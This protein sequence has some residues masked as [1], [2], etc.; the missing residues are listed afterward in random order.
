MCIHSAF[1]L[2]QKPAL[3]DTRQ[4]GFGFLLIYAII[5][6]IINLNT[7]IK[8]RNYMNAQIPNIR[9][10]RLYHVTVNW[11]TKQ[12]KRFMRE[13]L[14]CAVNKHD[15][16]CI[17]KNHIPKQFITTSQPNDI[18][19]IQIRVRDLGL[20]QKNRTYFVSEIIETKRNKIDEPSV[21]EHTA[22]Y[23]AYLFGYELGK[24][25]QTETLSDVQSQR[26]SVMS[27]IKE[28]TQLYWTW[29]AD[30]LYQKDMDRNIFFQEKL[31]DLTKTHNVNN[32]AQK[33]IQT[34][35]PMNTASF[36]A[37]I[38]QAK[39][40][41]EI[42]I[43]NANEMAAAI[44]NN[45]KETANVLIH[46]AKMTTQSV[47]SEP[48][49]KEPLVIS[50]NE[51]ETESKSVSETNDETSSKPKN[52][53]AESERSESVPKET[54]SEKQIPDD[55]ET[56]KSETSIKTEVKPDTHNNEK[57]S[58][59]SID[60]N[61]C[62][63]IITNNLVQNIKWL[64]A[65]PETE[66]PDKLTYKELGD[67]LLA[68]TDDEMKTL[69]QDKP[70]NFDIQITPFEYYIKYIKGDA[71]ALDDAK[72]NTILAILASINQTETKTLFQTYMFDNIQKKLESEM[73]TKFE[74][75]DVM[76]DED[77]FGDDD[78]P[79]DFDEEPSYDDEPSYEDEPNYDDETP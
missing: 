24:L 10:D 44:I 56:T 70:F 73:N 63:Q 58:E 57:S 48:S 37:I 78:F 7:T 5:F 72:R 62:N 47:S 77:P 34:N 19:D 36:D 41:A 67:P 14:I 38:E 25:A 51:T 60:I 18:S 74:T 26:M 31:N 50:T 49:T 64:Q 68:Y 1:S 61:E 66:N 21:L 45:A 4:S 30:F 69:L 33:S 29:A 17:A 42:I 3:P 32:F 76:P 23:F 43:K 8:E 55:A 71:N 16:E 46:T 59:L 65:L 40:Q 52:I 11:V 75:E 39:Q 6:G 12:E 20:S 35:T 53:Q 22:A 13:F 28:K 15:A 27:N 2:A 9:N 79:N 54:N